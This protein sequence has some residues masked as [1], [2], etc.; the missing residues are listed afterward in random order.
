MMYFTY[1]KMSPASL[2]PKQYGGARYRLVTKSCPEGFIF[3]DSEKRLEVT[4]LLLPLF[5]LRK[6]FEGASVAVAFRINDNTIAASYSTA[7]IP[8]PVTV[9][10]AGKKRNDPTELRLYPQ[11][12]D[13]MGW[14]IPSIT[15]QSKPIVAF[16]IGQMYDGCLQLQRLMG[17][18]P[19]PHKD[20]GVCLTENVLPTFNGQVS[21]GDLTTNYYTLFDDNLK[22]QLKREF[23]QVGPFNYVSPGLTT[24]HDFYEGLRPWDDIDFSKVPTRR[25]EFKKRGYGRRLATTHIKASC[26]VCVFARR[27]VTK[28]NFSVV[29]PCVRLDQCTGSVLIAEAEALIQHVGTRDSIEINSQFTAKQVH[30]LLRLIGTEYSSR[31][32]TPTRRT[33]VELTGFKARVTGIHSLY[34]EYTVH[35]AKG[36]LQRS[37]SFS[38]Y[39]ELITAIPE[40]AKSVATVENTLPYSQQ[41]IWAYTLQLQARHLSVGWGHGAKLRKATIQESPHSFSIGAQYNIGRATYA[42]RYLT[43]ENFPH[44]WVAPYIVGHTGAT[45]EELVTLKLAT[46]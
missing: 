31:V 36:D 42:R 20:S 17:S 30:A 14:Y 6:L 15:D 32:I 43:K 23:D 38:N 21:L 10:V 46:V 45:R 16:D 35:S 11:T 28:D 8:K 26:S 44:A 4:S 39:Q 5:K 13:L 25:E 27:E 22:A 2:V 24:E 12:R 33:T 37:K 29:K 1:C 34:Y 18:C 19:C 40:I 7:A 3:H 41:A 9:N